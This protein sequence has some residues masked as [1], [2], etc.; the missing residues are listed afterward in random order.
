MSLS[1]E[2]KFFSFVKYSDDCWEWEGY[3]DKDGYGGIQQDY[4][5]HKSHRFSYMY[6][7]GD[8]LENNYICHH[9][10]NPGCV[11]PFHLFQGAPKENT[12][13]MF[14]KGRNFI[15]EKNKFCK[16]GHPMNLA[17]IGRNI[18]LTCRKSSLKKYR[19]KNKELIKKRYN[20]NRDKINKSA[21]DRYHKKKVKKLACKQMLTGFT[22]SLED[23]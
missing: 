1:F 9:C 19:E 11:N 18:C 2:E 4:V 3:K 13:D 20:K 17:S 5:R 23:E 22:R 12:A 8:I 15:Q 7:V 6:F 16:Y 10:D 14:L 21:R